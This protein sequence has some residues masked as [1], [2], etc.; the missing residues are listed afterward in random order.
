MPVPGCP[1]NGATA[2]AIPETAEDKGTHSAASVNR[3]FPKKKLQK[4]HFLFL[5]FFFP[6]NI[7]EGLMKNPP[8]LQ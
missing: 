6:E 1:G 4:K 3:I 7:L 2:S 8:V 5:H